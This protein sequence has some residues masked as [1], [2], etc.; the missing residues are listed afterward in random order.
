MLGTAAF[1]FRVDEVG[2]NTFLLNVGNHI[3]S[4]TAQQFRRPQSKFDF[5]ENLKFQNHII[6]YLRSAGAWM[7][8]S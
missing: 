8:I 5:R 6:T 1:I 3:Q 2:H 7:A 4:Y